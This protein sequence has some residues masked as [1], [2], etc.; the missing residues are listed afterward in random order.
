MISFIALYFS[1]GVSFRKEKT[2]ARPQAGLSEKAV[3]KD[4]CVLLLFAILL[5][6]ACVVQT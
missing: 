4:L 5:S 2:K 1:S 6:L 3:L